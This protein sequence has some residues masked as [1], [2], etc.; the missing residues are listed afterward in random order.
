MASKS[1]TQVNLQEEKDLILDSL[2]WIKQIMSVLI[3][4]TVGSLH[5]TGILIFLGF[6]I[7]I[8]VTSLCYAWQIM[9]AH[10]LETWELLTEA[11]GPSFFCF[12]LSWIL[13]YTFI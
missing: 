6:G 9:K 1:V 4:L 10:D 2:Y 11:M 13:T 3:G 5:L 8:S 7:L 12:V